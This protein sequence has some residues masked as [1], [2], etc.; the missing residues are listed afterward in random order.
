M[1]EIIIAALALGIVYKSMNPRLSTLGKEEEQPY[2]I[3][4]WY[5]VSPEHSLGLGDINGPK[6]TLTNIYPGSHGMPTYELQDAYGTRTTVRCP[7][8][9]LS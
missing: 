8:I 7:P 3:P 5:Y 4:K 1:G 9:L 6:L 2:K